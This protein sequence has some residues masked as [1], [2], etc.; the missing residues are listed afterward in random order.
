MLK[1]I[2]W[3][4]P[5]ASLQWLLYMFANTVVV[6]LTVG[7][8]F[9]LPPDVIA[10]TS[11]CSLI[12]TGIACI[13]QSLVGHRFPL[14]EGHSGLM[15]GLLLTLSASASAMGMSLGEIGGG[16]AT[17]MLLSGFVVAIM[18]A[19]N[20]LNVL[21]R[22]FTQMV[23]SVFMFLLTFQL[24]FIFSKGMLP[25]TPEGVLNVPVSLFSIG[26]ATFVIVLKIK[27]KPAIGNFSILIGMAVGWGLYLILF[28][29][30]QA[31]TY[32]PSGFHLTLFPL[33]QPNWNVSIIAVTFLA[34]LLNLSNTVASVRAGAALFRQ[35]VTNAQ[36]N[37][38]Y[39]LAGLYSIGAALFGLIAYAPFASTIGF[40]E[41][42]RNF[43][44]KPFLIGGAL[45][46]M[47]GVI[48]VFGG[49]LATLPSNVGNAVLFS[50]YLQLFGTALKNIRGFEFN[51]ITIY[52]AAIPI[53]TGVCIMNL[54]TAIF[55]QVSVLLQPLVTNGFMMGVI[56][57]ILLENIVKWDK[58]G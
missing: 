38:T 3:T 9:D 14:M 28:P 27:G 34:S 26:L 52:R 32:T 25:L 53:L 51:S 54:D 35:T 50:A 29:D 7:A 33:G 43:D 58:Y 16:I 21:Q 37:R 36:W 41:S 57:S 13:L 11:R 5:L 1:S 20:L 24:L 45:M 44:R 49:I 31:A 10:G 12:F 48:P 4:T 56:I 8:A 55:S 6:P 46:V 39:I 15:W 22:I 42:T 17:G 18:G 2:S 19:L 47:L 40:L 23:M 30:Q